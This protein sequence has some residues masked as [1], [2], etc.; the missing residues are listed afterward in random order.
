MADFT[1]RY[2]DP[3]EPS[4][5]LRELARNYRG[6][7]CDCEQGNKNN[8]GFH[9]PNGYP[10]GG[11]DETYDEYVLDEEHAAHVNKI[12]LREESTKNY[13]MEVKLRKQQL[14]KADAMRKKRVNH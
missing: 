8:C 6:Q 13:L 11:E 10:I 4:H 14:E 12:Q 7:V 5:P 1:K 3:F 9:Y 2:F